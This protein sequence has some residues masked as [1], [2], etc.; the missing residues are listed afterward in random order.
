MTPAT[1]TSLVQ[2]SLDM[3]GDAFHLLVSKLCDM[4]IL[5]VPS[6][7]DTLVIQ[8]DASGRDLGAIMSVEKYGRRLYFHSSAEISEG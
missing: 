2:W 1:S 7:T 5:S 8:T 3:E 4:I 6:P